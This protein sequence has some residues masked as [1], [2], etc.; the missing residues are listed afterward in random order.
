MIDTDN[1][2]VDGDSGVVQLKDT[3]FLPSRWEIVGVD[4]ESGFVFGVPDDLNQACIK[5]VSY[6]F[7]LRGDREDISLASSTVVGVLSD[8][9]RTDRFA[10]GVQE[11]MDAY[12]RPTI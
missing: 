11:T 1:F 5:Q 7:R 3:R 9:Y 10:Q 12:R 8:V 6:E 2:V 4:Y